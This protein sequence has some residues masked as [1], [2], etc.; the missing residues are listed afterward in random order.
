MRWDGCRWRP[1]TTLA[2]FD[3]ARTLCR[4]SGDA[5]AKTVAAVVTMARADRAL[6]ATEDQ[7]DVGTTC[8]NTQA[9]TIHLDTGIERPPDPE[10]YITKIAAVA[11]AK[12][13]TPHP[14]WDGFL[15]RATDS[16]DELIGFL[17]RFLGYCMTGETKEHVL[18]FLHGAGANGKSVFVNTVL[19]IFGDYAVVAPME[20]FM[21][22]KHER[23]PTE[24]AKLRGAHLVVAQETEKGR[25]WDAV[26][27][28][29]LTSDDKLT[30][31]F[32]RQDFFDFKPTH[33]LIISG[34]HKPTLRSAEE[35]IRRRFL[36]V[37]FTVTIPPAERDPDLARKLEAEW[38]AILR[39]MIEGALEW[40]R[41]GL[42]VPKIVT[43]A[44]DD[45]FDEQD[46]MGLWLE[47]WTIRDPQAFTRTTQLFE[48]WKHFCEKGNHYV[49]SERAFS[50]EL[51]DHGFERIKTKNGR[52][53]KGI[54]LRANNGPRQDDEG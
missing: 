48:T 30:G 23:H 9:T 46:T 31:R 51:A 22:S 7:W 3:D 32:M 14:L 37:P 5:K 34:N 33:K 15:N 6:A 42:K 18:L 19:K 40:H 20:L 17:Q 53:F 4:D 45:Y 26:K 49:G 13:G 36:L 52:G 39:W 24:I 44:T 28:K 29:M 38:P 47:E 25:H 8:F 43:A 11:A 16:N 35:A 10:D 2:A 21:A 1:E 41:D 50:E 54:A 12:P 27:I